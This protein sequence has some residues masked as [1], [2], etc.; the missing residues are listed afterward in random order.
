MCSTSLADWLSWPA[1]T[2]FTLCWVKLYKA[3]SGSHLSTW[4]NS[5]SVATM[6]S[7]LFKTWNQKSKQLYTRCCLKKIRVSHVY[8]QYSIVYTSS[9]SSPT[10]RGLMRVDVSGSESCARVVGS[11]RARGKPSPFPICL[12]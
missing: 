2:S 12:T 4:L 8:I 3:K 7:P 10:L 11:C 9:D 6:L 5:R 1:G